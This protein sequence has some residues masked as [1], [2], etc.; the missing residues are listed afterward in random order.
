M[1]MPTI[2]HIIHP[3]LATIVTG[4][5]LGVFEHH[6]LPIFFLEGGMIGHFVE[7]AVC[8]HEL[9]NKPIISSAMNIEGYP[10]NVL[11]Q[12]FHMSNWCT[13]KV[14]I[15]LC[16]GHPLGPILLLLDEGLAMHPKFMQV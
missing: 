5:I 3:M 2:I 9:G 16:H 10:V 12:G 14:T 8:A 1:I 13:I 6:P 15:N 11:P 4:E 7:E